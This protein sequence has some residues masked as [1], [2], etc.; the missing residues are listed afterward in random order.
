MIGAVWAYYVSFVYPQFAV[1]PLITIAMVLMTFLG[2]RATVWGPPSAPSS[3]RPP[4]STWLTLGASSLYL[5]ALRR[6]VPAHDPAAA[7]R[8]CPVAWGSGCAS[9]GPRHRGPRRPRPGAAPRPWEWPDEVKPSDKR[10]PARGAR[11]AP[12]LRRRP[13]GQ[14]LLH[15]RRAAHH[16]RP[17]RAQRPGK[18][19]AFNIITGYLAAHSGEVH[20]DGTHHATGRT[21]RRM[22]RRGLTRTFQQ[23][24]V[25]PSSPCRKTSS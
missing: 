14:R 24:R 3:S 20:F 11:P 15:R 16:H 22:Y 4:S 10:N 23:A 8:H 18:T 19:T 6:R 25:F 12:Q 7:A 21:P 17:D 13:G 5:L 2:G 1:D 9:A